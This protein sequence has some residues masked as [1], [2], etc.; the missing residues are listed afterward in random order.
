MASGSWQLAGN[1]GTDPGSDFVGTTDGKPLVIKAAEITVDL[2]N[3][4]GQLHVTNN[5]GDNRVWMEAFASAGS[6]SATEFLLTGANGENVPTLSLFADSLSVRSKDIVFSLQSAG[7]GRLRIGCNPNDN[8]VWLEA[9]DSNADGSATEFLLT[10][11]LGSNVPQLS[12]H[13]D[14]AA[15][16]GNVAVSGNLVSP[17]ITALQAEIRALQ[18]QVVALQ[19][20]LLQLQT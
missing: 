3:G 20:A 12:F 15:F 17:T 1:A 2:A 13:A 11:A 4:G 7:G 16:N 8:R 6:S 10:G 18:T 19:N 14:N 5:P 9:F